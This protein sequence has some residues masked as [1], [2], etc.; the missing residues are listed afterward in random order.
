MSAKSLVVYLGFSRFVCFVCF[1]RIRQKCFYFIK[2]VRAPIDTLQSFQENL[3]NDLRR[4]FLLK[5]NP[6]HDTT[7]ILQETNSTMCITCT[8]TD[9]IIYDDVY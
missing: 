6:Q 7:V 4:Y 8:S 5:L 3:R 9:D 1:L 2:A